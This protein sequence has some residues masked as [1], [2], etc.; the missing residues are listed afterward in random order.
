MFGVGVRTLV[1]ANIA[2]TTLVIV[3]LYRI[4]ASISDRSSA[5]AACL[6]FVTI[7]AFGQMFLI[8]NYNFVCPYSHELT[9]GLLFALLALYCILRYNRRRTP[10]WFAAA[11]AATGLSFLT[12]PEV[13]AATAGAVALGAALTVW[14]ERPPRRRAMRLIACLVGFALTAPLAAFLLLASAM[15]AHHALRG[16]LGAWTFLFDQQRGEMRF[17]RE[18]SGMLDTGRSLRSLFLWAA[19]WVAVFLPAAA[20]ALAIRKAGRPRYAAAMAALGGATATLLI[21][22]RRIEW[23][24]A[25]RPLPI[26]LLVS[27]TVSFIVLVRRRRDNPDGAHRH[28]GRLLVV[29]LAF[30]LMGKIIL[31]VR[32]YHYGFALAMPATLVLVVAMMGWIPEFLS[33]R[34][35]CGGVYRAIALPVLVA[36]ILFH[37]DT[38][39]GHF[40]AKQ[41]RVGEGADAFRARGEG[42]PLNQMLGQIAS[43]IAPHQSL[44]VVP[45]GVML[46]YLAR[47]VNPTP[48]INIMPP[49]LAMFGEDHILAAFKEHPPDFVLLVHKDTSEYGFRY[50][51]RDYAKSIGR[52]LRSNYRGVFLL[53]AVPLTDERPGL[54]LLRRN[55]SGARRVVQP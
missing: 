24:Q 21:L 50:F 19:A 41:V 53:G 28:L 20:A 45:E 43:R 39:A 42:I 37:L 11:G 14:L 38:F 49:E 22:F 12:K 23:A 31:N 18:I 47:W 13:F 16:V 32:T 52:W 15:P 55:A 30:L 35:G 17:Y 5:T 9:H 7:F 1:F 29:A 44:A 26:A 34:G 48:Y 33:S 27:G 2:I 6:T 4:F 54:M 46:N 25:M 10:G 36:F 51:G 8:G 3:L 40:A